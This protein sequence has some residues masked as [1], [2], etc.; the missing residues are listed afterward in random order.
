MY[1]N[2]ISYATPAGVTTE[3]R[4]SLGGLVFGGATPIAPSVKLLFFCIAEKQ[5]EEETEDVI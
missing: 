2:R 3:R 5:E 1:V 4:I